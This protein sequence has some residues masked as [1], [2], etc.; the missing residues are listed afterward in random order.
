MPGGRQL[1]ALHS[2]TGRL[3]VLMHRGEYW[4]QK[5]DGEENWVVDMASRDEGTALVLDALTF[6]TKHEIKRGGAGV[7]SLFEGS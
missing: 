5:E 3:C 7:I 6:E 2:K 1:M 4:T